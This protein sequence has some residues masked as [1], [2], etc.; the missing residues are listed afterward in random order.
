ADGQRI[1]GVTGAADGEN[2]HV[3]PGLGGVLVGGDD[4]E[5][6]PLD[7]GAV[8]PVLGDDLLGRAGAGPGEPGHRAVVVVEVLHADGVHLS[9]FKGDLAGIGGG[10]VDG[11]VVDDQLVIDPQADTVVALGVEGIFLA[12]FGLHVTAPADAE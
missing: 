3:V 10:G 2:A 1:G 9:G 11:P 12:L 6:R 4:A 8:E 7:R 5:S